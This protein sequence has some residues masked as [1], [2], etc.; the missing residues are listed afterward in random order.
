MS[1][2]SAGI[3]YWRLSAFY[4]FYY[5]LLGGLAPYWS[6]Y[7]QAQQFGPSEI[8][9]LMAIL[10]VTRLLAPNLW[11]WLGD[12]AHCRLAMVRA[13][14]FLAFLFFLGFFWSESFWAYAFF[15]ALFSFFWTAVLPQFEVV[16]LHNLGGQRARYSQVRV[17]GS[18]GF[19]LT[20]AGLGFMLER[21]SLGWLPVTLLMVLGLIWL[22]SMQPLAEPKVA[23]T[24][25]GAGFLAIVRQR[26]VVA[27]FLINFL[28]QL[29][30][31]PYYTFYSLYLQSAGYGLDVIGL[32]W[33]LGVLAEVVL[34][35]LMHRLLARFSL[36]AI[37]GWSMVLTAA[38][39]A[40]VPLWLDSFW[41]MALVQLLHAFTFGAMH[42]ASIEFVHTRFAG[43]HQG[44]G[45]AL[46]SSLGFGAG[47][48]AGALLSGVLYEM[49][50]GSVT[51]MAG[52]LAAALAIPLAYWGLGES[53]A[54]RNEAIQG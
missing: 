21:V 5:A 6:V 3:P 12:V 41:L 44:Q 33:C 37:I 51:F 18:V 7:L 40:L 17:W 45:Q 34:F 47:G 14:S 35:L 31:G 52:A 28:L 48:S 49:N 8:G 43:P 16:T 27:F 26:P 4:F 53:Q 36:R 19:I 38:R 22:T 46:Y 39:W 24:R 32:L 29:S 50:G 9:Q 42:A 20:V 15:M 30:H 54:R 23:R 2:V 13:G 11:G 25:G 1:L 10:M